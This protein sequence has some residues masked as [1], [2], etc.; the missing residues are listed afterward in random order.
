MKKNLAFIVPL[1]LFLNPVY[2]DHC[3]PV[4]GENDY[5]PAHRPKIGGGLG[6]GG[7]KAYIYRF[8]I[9]ANNTAIPYFDLELES[10]K[11]GEM[12]R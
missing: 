11:R 6:V 10:L 3:Y 8:E 5:C 7:G 9:E 2:A 1:I 4:V 12:V